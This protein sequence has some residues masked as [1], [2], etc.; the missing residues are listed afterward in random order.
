MR[1][2]VDVCRS[3]GVATYHNIEYVD[4]SSIHME[5]RNERR[6]VVPVKRSSQNG[7]KRKSQEVFGRKD[8]KRPYICV[9]DVAIA[10]A[11]RSYSLYSICFLKGTIVIYILYSV[12][13]LVHKSLQYFK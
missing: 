2:Y 12:Y 8:S 13:L 7:T 9:V 3:C 11:R 4:D 6:N 1:I 10:K 5:S